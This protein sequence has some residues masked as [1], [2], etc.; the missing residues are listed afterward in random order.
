MI[1]IDEIE[2]HI[3]NTED[4]L[5]ANQ[6]NVVRRSNP[7]LSSVTSLDP[8]KQSSNTNTILESEN[9]KA[10][11]SSD[12]RYSDPKEREILIQKLLS[13]YNERKE[14]RK[15]E[16]YFDVPDTEDLTSSRRSLTSFNKSQEKEKKVDFTQSTI[17]WSSRDANTTNSSRKKIYDYSDDD[18]EDEGASELSADTLGSKQDNRER[19]DNLFF[20]SDI[21][22]SS[23]D[24]PNQQD[25]SFEGYSWSLPPPPSLPEPQPPQPQ[26]YQ[27]PPVIPPRSSR[28]VLDV[29][30]SLQGPKERG[31]TR[32]PPKL[33]SSTKRTASSSSV[34]RGNRS[35]SAD[36]VHLSTKDKLKEEAEKEF[37][38][39]HPFKPTRATASRSPTA[40]PTHHSARQS[41][42]HFFDRLDEMSKE[43]HQRMR[44]KEKLRS[45]LEK[46][47]LMQC[48]FQPEIT[49]KS[50]KLIQRKGKDHQTN[51]SYDIYK[52][53]EAYKEE[54]NLDSLSER[55]YQEAAIRKKRNHYL[56]KYMGELEEWN[57]TFQPSINNNTDKILQKSFQ[58]KQQHQQQQQQRVASTSPH[59]R[60]KRA[61]SLSPGRH[62]SNNKNKSNQT[63]S[64]SKPRYYTPI[65]QRV[66]ELQREKQRHL[67]E[68]K[69]S[70][71]EEQANVLTFRPSIAKK[72]KTLAEKKFHKEGYAYPLTVENSNNKEESEKEGDSGTE[73][74]RFLVKSDVA[75]R[76]LNE[77]RKLARRKQELL[78]QREQELAET[79]EKPV[80]SVGSQKLVYTNQHLR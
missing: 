53:E 22:T 80:M 78:Y 68:L 40:P 39:Q 20:A 71:E 56:S 24:V 15:T 9:S 72:S 10:T 18:D 64:D 60:A 79:L 6:E 31:R 69:Q 75:H 70:R 27:Q 48:T 12:N 26:Y 37:K 30:S 47:E 67:R 49:Q 43:H 35:Q 66:T 11:I 4:F 34:D 58:S 13:D 57:C 17:K 28:D 16:N 29:R 52:E 46:L 77:G 61:S 55:L 73:S 1:S 7:N 41:K 33:R 14:R 74:G 63:A 45:E 8:L 3:S 59:H 21:L 25:R 19:E 76:L 42:S 50:K 32:T 65:H 44:K 2:Q 5:K 62:L 36:R 51:T 38:K 54:N 23:L